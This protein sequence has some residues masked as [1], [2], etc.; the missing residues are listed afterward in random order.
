MKFHGN[1]FTLS[2]VPDILAIRD[3]VACWM[4]CKQPGKQ[5]TRIQTLRMRELEA[6]GCRVAVIHSAG[7]AKKFLSQES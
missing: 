3:G 6:A 5:P 7:E 1:Q 4:E 2:G